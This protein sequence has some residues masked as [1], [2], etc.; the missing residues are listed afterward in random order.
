MT[1]GIATSSHKLHSPKLLRGLRGMRPQHLNCHRSWAGAGKKAHFDGAHL[2][3]ELSCGSLPGR[4]A[5][6]SK[7]LHAFQRTVQAYIAVGTA[8][9]QSHALHSLARASGATAPE[10]GTKARQASPRA[11]LR[12]RGRFLSRGTISTYIVYF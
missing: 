12:N 1:R 4:T 5:P 11:R 7:C 6:K 8:A 3:T 9:S 10:N 2:L